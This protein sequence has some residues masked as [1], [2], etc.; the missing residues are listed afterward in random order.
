MRIL[1]PIE[2]EG[3]GAVTHVLTLSKELN[4]RGIKT[5][6]LFLNKGPAIDE[7]NRLKLDNDVV[8][9]NMPFNICAIYMAIN[10]IRA[11]KIDIIHTHTIR[12]NFI[13]RIASI[14][15]LKKLSIITTVHSYIADELKGNTIL[16]LK[17][18]LLCLREASTSSIVDHYICVSDKLKDVLIQRKYNKKKLS[19]ILNGVF[20]P[21]KRSIKNTRKA[22]RKE[23]EFDDSDIVVCIIGRLVPLK[24]HD[25]FIKAASRLSST[26]ACFKFMIVGDG[27]LFDS[28]NKMS[29]DRGLEN[30]VIFTGWRNDIN[31]ILSGV[32]IYVICSTIEGLNISI[33]EAMASGKP[34]IG[35]KVK[36]IYDIIEDAETGLLVN[37]DDVDSITCAIKKLADNAELRL[38][39]GLKGRQLIKLNYSINKMVNDT[40]QVYKK[41]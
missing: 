8:L 10:I 16:S 4:K 31:S 13:G 33:L 6:I 20:V 27:P 7:A 11:N 28:L 39:L 41:A 37:P 22:I 23:F 34:V 24:N 15:S 30:K 38:N 35:T 29:K 32:D 1:Y 25:L 9:N 18:R 17:D 21:E 26:N 2:G 12:G 14:L 3:G 19:V 40:Y 5:K 36:G